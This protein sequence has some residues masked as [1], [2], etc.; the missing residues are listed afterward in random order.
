MAARE[1]RRTLLLSIDFEDWHQLV[2][3][4]VGASGWQ[5]PGPAL[6]RQTE[7]LL[8]LLDELGVRATFFILGMAARAHPDLVKQ[9]AASGHEIGC[10]GDSHQLV[11]TQTPQ[12]FAA[13][14][15]RARTTIQELA[16]VAPAGYR[17]PAFS[18]TQQTPWA[19][20]VLAEAG[21]AYDASQHDSPRIR[22][23]VVASEFG[24]HCIQLKSGSL[25]E[26]PVAVWRAGTL[27]VPVGGASYWAALPTPLILKGLEQSGPLA[28]LYLHPYE[29]DPETL[30]PGLPGSATPSQRAQVAIRAAQRNLARL[31]A[32]PVLRAIAGRHQLIPYGEAYAQLSPRP[33]EGS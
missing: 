4:R 31:R 28:G 33:P 14:L 29:L 26:L 2:R 24:P 20:E 5:E 21:F 6:R 18:I 22:D 9:I 13:D 1:H 11:H 7:R 27:R 17:A 16:G 8:G 10:H 3:R 19:Y 32:T 23:R 15:R 12:E 30:R 25:W